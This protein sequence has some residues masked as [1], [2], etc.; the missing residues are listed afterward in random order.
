MKTQF[1][2]GSFEQLAFGRAYKEHISDT[3]PGGDKYIKAAQ[4][5][6]WDA[7]QIG[8]QKGGNTVYPTL[9]LL[10]REPMEPEM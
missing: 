4:N 6:L 5:A 3:L 10:D 2:E 1:K 7:W 9:P 8:M